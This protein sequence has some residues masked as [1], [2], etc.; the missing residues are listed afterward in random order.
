VKS[1][2]LYTL[3]PTQVKPLLALTAW[4][5][6]ADNLTTLLLR[7]DSIKR[8][9]PTHL[10]WVCSVL[11]MAIGG[12]HFHSFCLPFILVPAPILP[13]S[14]RP[15]LNFILFRSFLCKRFL[16][17][18]YIQEILETSTAKTQSTSHIKKG[19][20]RQSLCFLPTVSANSFS[21][22]FSSRGNFSWHFLQ[23]GFI[24]NSARPFLKWHGKKTKFQWK[25]SWRK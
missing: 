6:Q 14:E 5:S 19:E 24:S 13:R 22:F 3:G 23:T 20:S 15:S 17:L 10:L 25:G 9:L 2:Q 21:P 8:L 4:A 11:F 16:N 18:C 1:T 12:Q 7:Y